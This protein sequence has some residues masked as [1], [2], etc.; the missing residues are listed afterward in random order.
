MRCNGIGVRMQWGSHWHVDGE[1]RCQCVGG[2]SGRASGAAVGL[3][4]VEAQCR[5]WHAHEIDEKR[6]GVAGSVEGGCVKEIRPEEPGG[7][8]VG[9]GRDASCK[10]SAKAP[11]QLI[12]RKE[13]GGSMRL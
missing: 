13:M 6:Q 2:F 10:S 9:V 4:A 3:S 11:K 1:Q 5:R 7:H 8:D 12:R